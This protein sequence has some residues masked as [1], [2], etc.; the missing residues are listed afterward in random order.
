MPSPPVK[1]RPEMGEV[2][3]TLVPELMV[4]PRAG[5]DA[6]LMKPIELQ[7][8]PRARVKETLPAP[9]LSTVMEVSAKATRSS[10]T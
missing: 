2:V 8:S 7:C 10:S 9:G 5:N 1:T 4:R 3:A 6:S